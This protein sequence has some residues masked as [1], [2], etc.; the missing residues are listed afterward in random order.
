MVIW[1]TLAKKISMTKGKYMDIFLLTVYII[2]VGSLHWSGCTDCIFGASI[3]YGFG[4]ETA[5]YD[6]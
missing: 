6:R 4:A 5:E 3:Y 1:Y 2:E